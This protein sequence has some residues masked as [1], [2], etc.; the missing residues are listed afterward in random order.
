MGSCEVQEKALTSSTNPC[1]ATCEEEMVHWMKAALEE[2]T[3]EILSTIQPTLEANSRRKNVITYMQRLIKSSLGLEVF[4]YGS[5]P[6]MTY[7]PDGDIDLTVISSRPSIEDNMSLVSKVHDLLKREE[8]NVDAPYNVK[9]VHCI[10]AEV[11][12]VKCVVQ[13]IDVDVS[14]NQIGGISSLC[15]LEQVDQLIGK[16]YL[17][18]RSIILIK[19]WCYY[20]SR[21][22]GAHHGLISTYA[23]EILILYI[24]QQFHS[25]LNG[26][27][28]VLYKFLDYFSKFD[29]ERYCISLRGPIL[30]SSFPDISAELHENK[31][32][33]LLLSNEFLRDCPDV[34]AVPCKRAETNSESKFPLKHLNIVDP[35]KENNNLGRS[36]HKGNF[37]RI[38]SAFRYGAS[39]LGRIVM[40]PEGQIPHELNKFFTN[41]L[42]RHRGNY[43]THRNA[44]SPSSPSPF[45]VFSKCRYTQTSDIFWPE[46]KENQNQYSFPG[47]FSCKDSIFTIADKV[48][49]INLSPSLTSSHWDFFHQSLVM[50]QK[51]TGAF[52]PMMDSKVS[53]A[54]PGSKDKKKRRTRVSCLEEKK[55][56][57]SGTGAFILRMVSGAVPKSEEK[58]EQRGTGA[59]IPNLA[60]LS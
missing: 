31:N 10:D 27:F 18:K 24:F 54:T 40:L 35:L 28:Q 51:G 42:D 30:I 2:T 14:F 21:I 57:Q 20:E 36:I 60:F 56:L 17:F 46:L 15:F 3:T 1:K 26:P 47:N 44:K 19:A 8:D 50:K 23:L 12:L 32:G 41:T 59:Y 43:G 49:E 7:L 37:Y 22:L 6:L 38:R 52:I 55:K 4:P 53:A 39:K 33:G 29:W 13:D 5:V 25:S 34:F 48:S 45:D 58:R 9:D 16:G 11:K